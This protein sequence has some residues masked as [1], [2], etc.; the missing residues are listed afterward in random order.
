VA[1]SKFESLKNN[2]ISQIY[3]KEISNVNSNQAVP[4]PKNQ[5]LYIYKSNVLRHDSYVIFKVD[6]V[7]NKVKSIS[8]CDGNFL[9]GLGDARPNCLL[10]LF[11]R[12]VCYGVREFELKEDHTFSTEFAQEFISKNFQ[13]KGINSLKLPFVAYSQQLEIK[14]TIF[15]VKTK[16]QLRG[17]CAFKS[18]NILARYLLQEKTGKRYSR[19][20]Q[21]FKKELRS[22]VVQGLVKDYEK[23]KEQFGEEF[24]KHLEIKERLKEVAGEKFGKKQSGLFKTAISAIEGINAGPK[25]IPNTSIIVNSISRLMKRIFLSKTN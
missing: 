10:R 25:L 6:R 2:P 9:S 5:D 18:A 8:Y 11:G 20:Y 3:A 12:R 14:N 17:N 24:V 19:D 13:G 4:I 7:N 15:S 22:Q 1:S 16:Q 23:I 21:Q